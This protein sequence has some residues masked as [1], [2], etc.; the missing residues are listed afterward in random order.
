MDANID[1]HYCPRK[2]LADD[3]LTL[4]AIHKCIDAWRHWKTGNL[5]AFYPEPSDALGTMI[6]WVDGDVQD[7][8]NRVQETARKRQEDRR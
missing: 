3:M 5:G 2:V 4:R 8:T 7:Y 6:L 1:Y